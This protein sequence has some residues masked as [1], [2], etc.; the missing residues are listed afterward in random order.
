MILVT[1]AGIEH[2]IQT[3]ELERYLSLG[4]KIKSG[5]E[6]GTKTLEVKPKRSR[7]K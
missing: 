1:L 7:K 2:Y 4:W 3:H 5:S 6:S